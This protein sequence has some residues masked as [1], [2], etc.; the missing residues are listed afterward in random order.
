MATSETPK[1]RHHPRTVA[2]KRA[3]SLAI[4]GA[5]EGTSRVW[6]QVFVSELF[7]R[8]VVV[9]AHQEETLV[10]VEGRGPHEIPPKLPLALRLRHVRSFRI[11]RSRQRNGRA[12]GGGRLCFEPKL[13]TGSGMARFLD[14]S[15]RPRDGVASVSRDVSCWR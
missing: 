11:L 14:G 5:P 15:E 9:L 12:G 10:D 2:R 7:H 1:P 8:V 3:C 13:L 6:V 4:R